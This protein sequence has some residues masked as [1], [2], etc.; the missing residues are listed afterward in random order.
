MRDHLRFA[1]CY[2]HTFAWTGSD[3]FGGQTFERPW[4]GDTLAAVKQK[5]DVAFEMFS[6]LG[7]PY[8]CFHDADVRPDG[9]TF[10]DNTSNLNAW[11]R[12][13]IEAV[14]FHESIPGHHFQFAR[15]IES[16]TLQA[17]DE[18]VSVGSSVAHCSLP[19]HA[20]GVAANEEEHRHDLQQP[21]Q[22][23]C[24]LLVGQ[25]AV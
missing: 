9:A 18:P 20:V 13:Q 10:A 15:F 1:V 24:P 4:F 7:V 22:D 16:P 19:R 12:Y 8:Y 21:R 25:H 17:A 6:A 23:L 3:P 14:T 5:A 11:S 2:W